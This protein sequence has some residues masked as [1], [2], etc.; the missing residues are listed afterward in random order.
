MRKYC[1]TN[2]MC[3]NYGLFEYSGR[4]CVR[5]QTL[6]NV[7]M[8][9]AAH[10]KTTSLHSCASRQVTR[11]RRTVKCKKTMCLPIYTLWLHNAFC[12][13]IAE[14]DSVCNYASFLW[15]FCSLFAFALFSSV[16]VSICAN[17][18]IVRRLI[19][20]GVWRNKPVINGPRVKWK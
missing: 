15:F 16:S 20:A 8:L 3:A 4:L 6:L 9:R 12:G 13:K 17:R 11:A 5:A 18:C 7:R 14:N 10:A 19:P 1:S 2:K